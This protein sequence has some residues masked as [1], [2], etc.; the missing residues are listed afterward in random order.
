AEALPAFGRH[1]VDVADHP[2]AHRLVRVEAA[3]GQGEAPR[4]N[5]DRPAE[6]RAASSLTPERGD[7][8][9]SAPTREAPD[10]AGRGAGGSAAPAP[11][12]APA[13]A[14]PPSPPPPPPE[15]T[16]AAGGAGGSE[17]PPSPPGSVAPR[18]SRKGPRARGAARPGEGSAA[19][20]DARRPGAAAD[21]ASP[22]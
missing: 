17:E 15:A 7:S 9:P 18:S 22:A 11:A 20:A 12:A 3:L 2:A 14:A 19:A 1:D 16:G 5:E 21:P 4:S 8:H 6:A 13:A 10:P